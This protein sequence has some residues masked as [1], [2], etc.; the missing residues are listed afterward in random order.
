LGTIST[1]TRGPR[2]TGVTGSANST[3]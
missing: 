3:R 1:L 2:S